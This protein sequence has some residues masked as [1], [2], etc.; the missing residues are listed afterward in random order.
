MVERL[1]ENGS[2]NFAVGAKFLHVDFAPA[3]GA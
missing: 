2:L 3:D 1:C